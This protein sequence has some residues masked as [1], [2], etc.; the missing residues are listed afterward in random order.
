M[1]IKTNHL[2]PD[3]IREILSS[4]PQA[5]EI[6][7]HRP[8][9]TDVT[10][11]ISTFE[12]PFCLLQ[13]LT[14]IQRHYPDLTVLVCDSSKEPLFKDGHLVSPH[15]RWF[16]LPY[17]QGHTLGASRNHLVHHVQTKYL[18]LCDDDHVIHVHTN[19][20]GM[21]RFLE[22]NKY[23][24]VG[25][26]QGEEDY[27]LAVFEQIEDI[28]YQHFYRHHGHIE[29]DAV[30]CDRVSNTF[31]ARTEAVKR[32]L[33]EDRVYGSEHAEFF[34][35]ASRQKLKI[36]QMIGTYVD[37]KRD[38]ET[39]NSLLGYLFG[40]FLPHRDLKYFHLRNGKDR[41]LEFNTKQLEQ[42]YCFEKNQIKNIIS[43]TNKKEK[44]AFYNLIKLSKTKLTY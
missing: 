22:K 28:V 9:K 21:Y 26:C 19:L 3:D 27:G 16:V 6:A 5:S 32:V 31:M 37:H 17:N 23:D 1:A 11:I 42:K 20:L 38:C 25:G 2:T 36:A 41:L 4:W 24:I 33:W 8:L 10:F 40:W 43:V 39:N 29:P 44:K 18:F 30:K 13:L 7:D 35:R 12:R 14:S 34:L 15:I